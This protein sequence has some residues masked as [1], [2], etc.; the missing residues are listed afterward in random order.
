MVTG[1]NNLGRVGVIHHIEKH[2]GSFTIVHLKDANGKEFAT[3]SQNVFIIGKGK[4]PM[5][6]LPKGQGLY[7]SALE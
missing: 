2:P 5:I 1:G 3:R 7:L 6:S 4:K